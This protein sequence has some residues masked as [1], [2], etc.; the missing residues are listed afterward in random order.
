MTNGKQW[1]WIIELDGMI[2]RDVHL[3]TRDGLRR[4]GRI[5]GVNTL[6]IETAD[7]PLL[8][9]DSIE[10]NGDALDR[11]DLRHVKELRVS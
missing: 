10:L 8:I 5:T 2:G 1:E 6:E 4:E 3:E 9:P 11:I 7:E